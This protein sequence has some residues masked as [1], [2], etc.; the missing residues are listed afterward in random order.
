M[1]GM[2][3]MIGTFHMIDASLTFTDYAA[4]SIII[5]WEDPPVAMS[6][7]FHHYLLNLQCQLPHTQ[8]IFGNTRVYVCVRECVYPCMC[9][10]V[11]VGGTCIIYGSSVLLCILIC[12]KL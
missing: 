12:I 7:K 3:H 4:Y 5:T 1:I 9:A 2:F 8:V 10:H 11:C 6:L